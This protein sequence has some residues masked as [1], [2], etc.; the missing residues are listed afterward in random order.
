MIYGDF[1][2]P[3]KTIEHNGTRVMEI[4]GLSFADISALCNEHRNDLNLVIELW[5]MFAQENKAAMA[6][7]NF[8]DTFTEYAIQLLTSA[9]GLIA[10]VIA[11]CADD[12]DAAEV[13]S[14]MPISVQI[15]AI[16]AISTLTAND[17]G[18]AKEMLGKI[19]SLISANVPKEVKEQYG[20]IQ[21]LKEASGV[22]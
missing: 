2:I 13:I 3:T 16:E 19:M 22:A 12:V 14:R 6:T 11:V 10:K 1:H 7:N 5:Q 15:N 17:F 9:P 8:V 4:R 18:G 20:A 21:G